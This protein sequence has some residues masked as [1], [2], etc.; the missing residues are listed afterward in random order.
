MSEDAAGLSHGAD[1][2]VI[3][4]YSGKPFSLTDP[5]PE[6]I[7]IEDIAHAL[8][9]LCRWN[10]HLRE[11]Y[12]VA[13]HCVLVSRLVP[14]E[15]ALQGLLHDAAEA[16]IGDLSSPLKYVM[17]GSPYREI[18]TNLSAMICE[19]FGTT[20]PMHPT[21]KLADNVSAATEKRDLLAPAYWFGNDLPNAIAGW[22]IR[23]L[24]SANAELEYLMRFGELTA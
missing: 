9:L 21:V 24:G 23:P 7:R 19:R 14:D 12:S 4:V 1:K 13:E 15:W 16:Y 8:S 10:G 11:F 18:E 20:W 5:R 22:K 17:T 6:D 2:S 3:A